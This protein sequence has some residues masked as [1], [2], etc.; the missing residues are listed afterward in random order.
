[1]P[2]FP[3]SR[4]A[5]ILVFATL[6]PI[7][8]ASLDP[9]VAAASSASS[10]TGPAS[11]AT[12]VATPPAAVPASTSVVASS[13]PKG[14]GEAAA[15]LTS[16]T[17]VV[18]ST[19]QPLDPATGK[20]STGQSIV[21]AWIR[22]PSATTWPAPVNVLAPGLTRSYDPATA[23]LPDGTVLISAG[24]APAGAGACLPHSSVILA[25]AGVRGGSA[26][27]APVVVDDERHAGSF[28]DRPIVAT[29]KTGTVWVAWSQGTSS[30]NC[31]LVGST[32]QIN[33]T[34][35]SDQG[36]T[37]APKVA[38]PRSGPGGA[39]GVRIVPLGS[40]QAFMSWSEMSPDHRT[41]R[42]VTMVVSSDG[43]HGP[44]KVIWSGA[45]I[46]QTLPGASFY[47]FTLA[48]STPFD[49]QSLSDQTTPGQSNVGQASG[50]GLAL[51]WPTESNGSSVIDLAISRDGGGT[52]TMSQ[53][54]PDPGSDLLLPELAATGDH[55][56]LLVYAQHGR[57]GDTVG[58]LAR[59]VD[60]SS[61]QAVVGPPSALTTALPGPGYLELGEF[62]FLSASDHVIT[63]SVVGAGNSGAQLLEFTWPLAAEPAATASDSSGLIG[64][65]GGAGHDRFGTY[66]LFAGLIVILV[67]AL[68]LTAGA[69]RRHRPDR[70]GPGAPHRRPGPRP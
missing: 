55:R 65:L 25:R 54:A 1:M 22:S 11:R 63:G 33:F 46:A 9:A 45:A 31:Q 18:V 8:F 26:L 3:A 57:S 70:T 19:T 24:A 58:Y 59:Y 60:L 62:L 68:G 29:S 14:M 47:S 61:A 32:D 67:L 42:V 12:G 37:F 4:A 2:R 16:R 15:S 35:S 51:A 64:D 7:L 40:G 34:T 28:D 30:S 13:P 20:P 21:Q 27:S 6:V 66:V 5:L 10:T 17:N 50:G 52:W 49:A 44:P 53:V 23:V 69:L 56:L 41:D 39:F 43:H 36:L 48:T 38:L